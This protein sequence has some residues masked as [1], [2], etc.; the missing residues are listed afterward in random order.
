M[1]NLFN[2][3]NTLTNITDSTTVP[4]IDPITGQ[5]K[6]TS[7]QAIKTFIGAL[8]STGATGVTGATG[9]AGRDGT[10]GVNGTTGATGYIGSTGATGVTGYQGSTGAT[11]P[12]GSDGRSVNIV[13]S[14]ANSASLPNP[15]TGN[16]GDGFLTEDLKELW[17]W[18]GAQ[19]INVGNIVGPP[20]STGVTGGPGATGAGGAT[21]VQGD[22]GATGAQGSTGPTG[23]VGATGAGATGSTGPMGPI[24]TTLPA[25]TTTIGGLIVGHNLRIT[26]E[27]TLSSVLSVTGDIPPADAEEGDQWWDSFYGR[28]Y[29]YY[30][31]TWVEMSPQ[32]LPG[33]ATTATLGL[34]QIGS[35]ITVNNGI[36]SVIGA[37]G[38]TGATGI[39]GI[40]GATGPQGISGDVG[41][42]GVQGDVGATGAAGADGATGVA[43][44]DGATGATGPKGDTGL[45]FSIAKTYLSVAAL[46]ADTAPTGIV[47]GEFAIIETGS[48]EDPENSRLYLW[49]GSSYIYTTDLSGAVGIT[50]AD[51]ATGMSGADGA[52][53]MSGADGATGATGPIG[54][55]TYTPINSID[56]LGS[57]TVATMTAGL[58]ELAGRM[59]VVEGEPTNTLVNGTYTVTLS[60]TGQLNLPGA[61]NTESNNARIQSTDSIDILSNLSK[62]TFDTDGVLT[63]PNGDLTI[64]YNG[65]SNVIEA[66]PGTLF[67]VLGSGPGGAVGF[68]WISDTTTSTTNA[69]AVILNSPIASTSGTVQI[70]TGAVTGPTAENTW[71][72]GADGTLVAPGHLLPNA[73][74]AYDLGSTSSQWRSIYVGTGTVYIGGVALGVNENNYVTVDGNPIITVNTAGNFTV[75]GDT[76]LILGSVVISD[77]APEAT[78]PGSQ[79]FNTVEARTYVAYN[80]QWVDSSPTVLAPPDTNPTVESVTFNDNTTQTTAWSGSVSYNDLTDKPV[81]PTFVGG[82]GASTW[83]TAD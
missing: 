67:T 81:T 40:D 22:I 66:A 17:V 49:N 80:E 57:P 12:K 54:P 21:G 69:A 82:G 24:G 53:G 61:A 51:G 70:V 14:V 31:G 74:L 23:D 7:F 42:T 38:E 13:G 59:V 73:D 72:F 28:G 77:T 41:A 65:V 56:W 44:V 75:Q 76:N 3:Y 27:G 1:T 25:T 63:F 52:T 10:D 18:D 26:T 60:T 79:W 46:T 39:Q 6:K 15:Y 45:G 33:A 19:F 64:G 68:Q 78:T 47:T 29:V 30:S 83:L 43:G 50:G 58:D 36:I 48:V 62:W 5:T 4:V 8:G 9:P 2:A 55:D 37:Q 16:L 20:G 34:V 32:V 71:E 35:G 11:G